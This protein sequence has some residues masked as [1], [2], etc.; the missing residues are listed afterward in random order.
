MNY[1]ITNEW[2]LGFVDGEGCFHIGINNNKSMRLGKQI[3]PEFTIVQHVRDVNLLY[4]IKDYLKC[5][6]VQ[7]NRGKNDIKLNQSPRWCYRVRA[8]KDLNQIIIPFF[9]KHSLLT[10]KQKDFLDFKTVVNMINLR[11]HLTLEGLERIKYIK[12]R[13]NKNRIY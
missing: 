3:I 12:N 4:S 9:D 6:I 1:K 8:I 7:S 10:T 5:G 11:K 2:L 13:M